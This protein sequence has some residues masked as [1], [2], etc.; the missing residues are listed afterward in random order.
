MLL[1]CVCVCVQ[2]NKQSRHGCTHAQRMHC[3]V[4]MMQVAQDD[5]RLEYTLVH[6]AFK[7]LAW[8]LLWLSGGGEGSEETEVDACLFL[9]WARALFDKG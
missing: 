1:V 6:N 7:Q 3:S 5:A 9:P 8:R 2:E 4:A